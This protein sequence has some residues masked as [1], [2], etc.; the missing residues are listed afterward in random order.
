[1]SV[2]GIVEFVLVMALCL[3]LVWMLSP[4]TTKIPQA[5]ALAAFL[6]LARWS[7]SRSWLAGRPQ[8]VVSVVG[9]AAASVAVFNFLYLRTDYASWKNLI[10]ALVAVL[11]LV[12]CSSFLAWSFVR[13]RKMPT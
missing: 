1:M 7:V 4:E 13:Q 10:S 12:L 3:A 6:L 8:R 11:V 9:S 5:F 2:R